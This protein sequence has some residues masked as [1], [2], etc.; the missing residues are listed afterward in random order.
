M[1]KINHGFADYYYLT[2]DNR[3]YSEKTKKILKPVN[4]KYTYSLRTICGTPKSTNL[5]E[6]YR[7]LHNKEYCI[8]KVENLDGEEWKEI[9]GYKGRYLISNKGR[10]KSLCRYEAYIMKQDERKGYKKVELYDNRKGQLFSIHRLVAKYFCEGYSEYKDVHHKDGN[11]KN[12]V[13]TNLVCLTK[14]E[15]NK[16]HNC[17]KCGHNE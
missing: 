10:C 16:L 4:G 11:C 14:Y 5:K 8:D 7:L 3:I 9:E 2:D 1:R 13:Y 17:G 15:H 6:I 12:N